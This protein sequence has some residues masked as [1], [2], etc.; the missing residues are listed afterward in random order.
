MRDVRI[1]S[2][3]MRDESVP[4]TLSIFDDD[5]VLTTPMELDENEKDKLVKRFAERLLHL[6]LA[7][8]DWKEKN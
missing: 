2:M 4:A 3:M 1:L 7:M 6:G 5:I 8:H